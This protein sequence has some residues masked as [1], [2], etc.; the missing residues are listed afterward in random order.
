MWITEY[1]LVWSWLLIPGILFYHWG[2]CYLGISIKIATVHPNV[3][4]IIWISVSVERA[5][6]EQTKYL[7]CYAAKSPMIVQSLIPIQHTLASQIATLTFTVLYQELVKHNSYTCG[8]LKAAQLLITNFT[9][10]HKVGSCSYTVVKSQNLWWSTVLS[11]LPQIFECTSY[12][13]TLLFI[14]HTAKTTWLK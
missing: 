1:S 7:P 13:C 11:F 12:K 9:C 2:L 3:P 14:L 6:T 5:S 10:T 4:V 8:V